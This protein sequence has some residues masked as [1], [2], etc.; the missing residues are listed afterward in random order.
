MPSR[1][2]ACDVALGEPR[3][4]LRPLLSYALPPPPSLLLLLLALHRARKSEVASLRPAL[5]HQ[6]LAHGQG[7]LTT[8]LQG[9]PFGRTRLRRPLPLLL[10]VIVAH[11]LQR[12]SLRL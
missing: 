12:H 5:N 6:L 4:P 9:P 2:L 10:K 1:E 7:I 3:P 8:P 11:D